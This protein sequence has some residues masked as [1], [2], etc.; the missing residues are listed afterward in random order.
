MER[1]YNILTLFLGLVLFAYFISQLTAALT[2]LKSL[3]YETDK[4]VST[5]KKYLKDNNTPR[6]LAVRIRRFIEHS[7]S[8]RAKVLQDKDVNVLALLS[9][10]LKMELKQ[11]KVQPTLLEYVIF[12]DLAVEDE[13]IMRA[14]CVTACEN[15]SHAPG[16]VIFNTTQVAKGMYFLV[17]GT[18]RYSCKWDTRLLTG[19]NTKVESAESAKRGGSSDDLP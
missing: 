9:R 13:M 18:F 17:H 12:A 2:R 10:G 4:Q 1:G 14:L 5:L 7:L 11:S 6:H 8:E 15:E 19:M 16:D 3:T